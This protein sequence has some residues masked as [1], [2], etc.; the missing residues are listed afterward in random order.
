M[1]Y[2]KTFSLLNPKTAYNFHNENAFPLEVSAAE[3]LHDTS[4]FVLAYFNLER[5]DV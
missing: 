4:L 3:Q 1:I 5:F 2:S